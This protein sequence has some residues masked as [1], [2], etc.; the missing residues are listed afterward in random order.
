MF[1]KNRYGVE[2]GAQGWRTKFAG[3]VVFDAERKPNAIA[4]AE[5][6]GWREGPNDYE[7]SIT[8]V[9]EQGRAILNPDWSFAIWWPDADKEGARPNFTHSATHPVASTYSLA[10]ALRLSMGTMNQDSRI[11]DGSGGP[12]ESWIDGPDV[13]CPRY[14]W[15]W[16]GDGHALPCPVFRVRF[17]GQPSPGTG[18]VDIKTLTGAVIRN[19]GISI[20][21]LAGGE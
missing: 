8:V 5:I 1:Y 9:D 3:P 19:M 15:G 12:Y 6:I 21:N 20:R 4:V 7:H 18:A 11:K 17:K 16:A 2:L 14:R 10:E 13:E